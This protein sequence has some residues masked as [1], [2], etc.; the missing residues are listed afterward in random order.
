ME[1][2]SGILACE[3][4]SVATKSGALS[5]E[6]NVDAARTALRATLEEPSGRELL[7]WR[8][9]T[10]GCVREERSLAELVAYNASRWTW[11]SCRASAGRSCESVVRL[12]LEVEAGGR[13]LRL[14]TTEGEM[15]ARR[16]YMPIGAGR[17]H[18]MKNLR[19][20][21]PKRGKR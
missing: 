15:R 5:P 18:T 3:R 1:T 6:G 9:R 11:V 21:S 14:R 17:R 2:V 13:R 12:G 4:R 19:K 16:S 7:G 20:R 8:L 10:S